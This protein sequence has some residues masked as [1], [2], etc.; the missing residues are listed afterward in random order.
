MSRDN[1]DLAARNAP[2]PKPIDRL[3]RDLVT[4]SRY[5]DGSRPTDVIP[6]GR[7]ASAP[8]ALLLPHERGG[9]PLDEV[10]IG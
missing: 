8:F 2:R 1:G 6:I 4:A 3:R 5:Q 7:P 10:E 9:R